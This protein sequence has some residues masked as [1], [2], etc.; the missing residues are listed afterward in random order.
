[1]FE[2]FLGTLLFLL[3][4]QR[5][6]SVR[7]ESTPSAITSA[8]NTSTASAAKA[9][10]LLSAI[11]VHDIKAVNATFLARL[12]K[13]QSLWETK[14]ASFS[15]SLKAIHNEK[16]VTLMETIQ[17]RLMEIN[18]NQTTL[19]MNKLTFLSR[20]LE[21]IK[22]AAEGFAVESGKDPSSVVAAIETANTAITDA[23]SAVTIQAEKQ[24]IISVSNETTLKTNVEVQKKLLVSDLKKVRDLVMNARKKVGDALK[25]LK[26]YTGSSETLMISTEE[27]N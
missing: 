8:S 22:K 6:G 9:A 15:A 1:M 19:L 24:Y 26:T 20:A 18:K 27:T 4:F 13:S 2:Q 23:I 25:A 21:Q 12:E 14:R 10:A 5:G 17:N 3:G 7:G 16:K 11:K